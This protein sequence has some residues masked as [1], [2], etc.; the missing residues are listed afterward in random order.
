MK[1]IFRLLVVTFIALTLSCDSDY[2][3]PENGLYMGR[4]QFYRDPD[5]PGFYT[6]IFF[7]FN[8]VTFPIQ[9]I[10][11]NAYSVIGDKIYFN[12]FRLRDDTDILT[13]NG[14]F[15]LNVSG[16]ELTLYKYEKKTRDHTKLILTKQ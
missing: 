13:I 4:F 6:D 2:V 5:G 14:L 1:T 8:Y 16:D 15:E 3:M 10:P 11:E 7:E 9:Q 12:K